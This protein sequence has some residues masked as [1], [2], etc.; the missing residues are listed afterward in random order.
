MLKGKKCNFC[1]I[2]KD[3]SKI[4]GTVLERMSSIILL[5]SD[6]ECSEVETKLSMLGMLLC[7]DPDSSCKAG[8]SITFLKN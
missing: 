5:S 1:N 2:F 6:P 4:Q 8:L 3:V 7:L